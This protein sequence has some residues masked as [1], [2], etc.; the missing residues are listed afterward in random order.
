M[1]AYSTRPAPVTL[2]DRARRYVEKMPAAVAGSG[3][4]DATFHVACVLVQGFALAPHQA[5]PLFAEYNQRCDPPWSEKE[6]MHKL[7]GAERAGGLRVSGGGVLPRGCLAQGATFV[8]S[9]KYRSY[10]ALPEPVK[11]TYKEDVLMRFAGK[12]TREVDLVWLANR[13]SIDPATVSAGHFLAALYQP[14]EHVVVFTNDRSAVIGKGITMWPETEPPEAGPCGVWYLVQPV[15]GEYHPTEDGE[16]MS[17]RS[18]EAVTS[19]R[20]MTIESDEAHPRLWLGAIAQLPLRIAAIYTS[21]GRSVH[22]LVR[23]DAATKGEWDDTKNKMVEGLVTIG[24]DRKNMTAVRLSRLPGCT[25]YGKRDAEGR[26]VQFPQ[27]Q[28]Q[29]L[30]Y[31][32]PS[33]PLAPLVDVFARRD[34]VDY[35][36]KVSPSDADETGGAWIKEGL[37]YYAGVSAYCAAA[38][39]E[40]KGDVI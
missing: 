31:L 1:S 4:H 9:D 27:P 16:K 28:R 39:E 3:G 6:L 23:V 20:Y 17:C 14:G 26:Y 37:E 36:C 2:E 40:M 34:V 24:A 8:P 10:H 13:S 22:T 21:G 25:R 19:W 7:S 35:W 15:T 29:K 30:L 38:L 33:P 32:N 5:L 11:S 18:K 12:W